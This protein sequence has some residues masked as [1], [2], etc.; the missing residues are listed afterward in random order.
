AVDVKVTRPQGEEVTS[1][2]LPLN[3]PA[4]WDADKWFEDDAATAPTSPQKAMLQRSKQ[5][6]GLVAA[7]PTQEAAMQIA[8]L[9]KRAVQLPQTATP[10]ERNIM[11]GLLLM[12]LA[13]GGSLL[14]RSFGRLGAKVGRAQTS[15]SSFYLDDQS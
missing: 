4:G 7:A 2:K 8:Q 5:S 9:N 11:I 14:F 1:T 3:L 10:A 6:F 13:F 15:R 12:I